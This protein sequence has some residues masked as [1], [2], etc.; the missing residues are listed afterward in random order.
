MFRSKLI[1]LY[2]GDNVCKCKSCVKFMMQAHAGVGF[3]K[4]NYVSLKLFYWY[5]KL[6]QS[7]ILFKQRN[8]RE[9]FYD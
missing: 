4:K 1:D 3:F 2:D 8:K 9:V 7:R 6:L 5:M